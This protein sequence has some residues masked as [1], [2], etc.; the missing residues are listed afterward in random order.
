M[1]RIDIYLDIFNQEPTSGSSV[2][3]V[4][5]YLGLESDREPFGLFISE[6]QI[7]KRSL[8]DCVYASIFDEDHRFISPVHIYTHSIIRGRSSEAKRLFYKH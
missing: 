1:L 4:P 6:L 3:R 8:W 7:E 5:I 2:F